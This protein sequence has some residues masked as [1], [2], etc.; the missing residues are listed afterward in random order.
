MIVQLVVAVKL[1]FDRNFCP[2][3]WRLVDAFGVGRGKGEQERKAEIEG[4][5]E[6]TPEYLKP[7]WRI[8]PNSDTQRRAS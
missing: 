1:Y 3:S 6:S 2:M 4:W 7:C 8:K 5:M